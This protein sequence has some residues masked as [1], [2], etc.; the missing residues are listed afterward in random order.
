MKKS[1]AVFVICLSSLSPCLAKP[2]HNIIAGI[3]F[4]AIGGIF[5]GMIN[6]ESIKSKYAYDELLASYKKG[7]SYS[8][9]EKEHIQNHYLEELNIHRE[10]EGLYKG[11]SYVT[12]GVGTFFLIK[13]IVGVISERRHPILK[14]VEIKPNSDYSGGIL[15]YKVRF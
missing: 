9:H 7:S 4:L 10:R 13:G 11:V 15:A 12:F 3:G 14:K 1:L 2:A 6:E 8:Y 5:Q